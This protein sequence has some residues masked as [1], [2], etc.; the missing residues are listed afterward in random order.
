[1]PIGFDDLVHD[2][3]ND[4]PETIRVFLDLRMRYDGC[5]IACFHTEDNACGGHH[6]DRDAFLRALREVFASLRGCQKSS[7]PPP[8]N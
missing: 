5:P 6:V 3:M 7:L 2:V 1:M 4:W 8:Q